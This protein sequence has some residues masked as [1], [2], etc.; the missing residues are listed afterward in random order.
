MKERTWRQSG[1]TGIVSLVQLDR[2]LRWGYGADFKS[3]KV[4]CFSKISRMTVRLDQIWKAGP[5]NNPV[6]NRVNDARFKDL[7]DCESGGK[8][9]RLLFAPNLKQWKDGLVFVI[10]SEANKED[11]RSEDQWRNNLPK[12]WSNRPMSCP[13]CA[14]INGWTMTSKRNYRGERPKPI[15]WYSIHWLGLN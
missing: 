11:V 10:R 6:D 5:S 15:W 1:P 7:N 12:R 13:A 4:L 9:G 2:D 3:A 8:E 14:R